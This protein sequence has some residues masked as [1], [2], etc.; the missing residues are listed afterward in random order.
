MLTVEARINNIFVGETFITNTGISEAG[1]TIYKVRYIRSEEDS[2]TINFPIAH[3]P[4]DGNEAL[5]FAVYKEISK[6]LRRK[7]K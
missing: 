6:R 4:R 3:N 1:N 7:H 5:I 2:N